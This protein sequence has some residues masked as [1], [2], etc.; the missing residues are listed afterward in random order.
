ML[1]FHRLEEEYRKDKIV[2]I[3]LNLHLRLLLCN[4]IFYICTHPHI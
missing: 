4:I 3:H 2:H 1:E